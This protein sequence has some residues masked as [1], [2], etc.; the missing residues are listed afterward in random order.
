MTTIPARFMW[1]RD[2]SANWTSEDP[3]LL[4]GEPGLE[5]DTRKFKIG[6]GATAWTSLAYFDGTVAESVRDI[7]GATLVQ[8]TGIGITVD[9]G[10]NTIT[11]V[12]DTATALAWAALHRFAAGI[13]IGGTSGPL[14]LTGTGTPE[15][16]VAAP[17][18]S[19][20]MRED[21]GAGTSLYVK[22]SGTGNTGWVAK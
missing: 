15:G 3:V 7:I 11:I 12:L 21:G 14:V 18:G 17:V 10:A 16:A 9:D 19:Q 5:T 1:R 2:T 8:G 22:E 20:F 13:R 4:D 6:D